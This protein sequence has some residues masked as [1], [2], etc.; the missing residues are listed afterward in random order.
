MGRSAAKRTKGSWSLRL[1]MLLSG[2]VSGAAFAEL[3]ST[4]NCAISVMRPNIDTGNLTSPANQ[5]EK[6]FAG[7]VKL[8][9]SLLERITEIAQLLRSEEQT[10]EF[11]SRF[12]I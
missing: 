7:L 2:R 1:E 8:P 4:N 3:G 6:R 12:D 5:R 9:V 11:Q 10:S